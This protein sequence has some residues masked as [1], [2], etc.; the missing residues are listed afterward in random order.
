MIFLCTNEI[1]NRFTSLDNLDEIMDI[2]SAAEVIR[3]NIKTSAKENTG[4]HRVKSNKPWF[5]DE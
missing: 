1:S 4:Y 5:D 2:N 3:E